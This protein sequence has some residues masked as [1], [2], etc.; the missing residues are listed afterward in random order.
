M[1][2]LLMTSVPFWGHVFIDRFSLIMDNFLFLHMPGHFYWLLDF[3]NFA[4]MGDECIH[5]PINILKLFV[6]DCSETM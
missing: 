5:V 1:S 6:L 3:V 4:L 2:C